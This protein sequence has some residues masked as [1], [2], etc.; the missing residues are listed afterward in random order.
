MQYNRFTLRNGKTYVYSLHDWT[1]YNK[2][3]TNSNFQTRLMLDKLL[4][5]KGQVEHAIKINDFA[6][7]GYEF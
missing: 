3:I 6:F 5:G 1:K 7:D 4:Y 2:C